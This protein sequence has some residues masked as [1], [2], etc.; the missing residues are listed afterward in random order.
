MGDFFFRQ[1]KYTQI[2]V[3]NLLQMI[4][5]EIQQYAVQTSTAFVLET[6]CVATK[7]LDVCCNEE[8]VPKT[9][10]CRQVTVLPT[11]T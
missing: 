1:I 6:Q 9:H 3:G 10:S 4:K 7:S 11:T 8:I 5:Y 2:V